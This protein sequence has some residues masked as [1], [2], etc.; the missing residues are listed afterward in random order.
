M[1]NAPTRGEAT[2]LSLWLHRSSVRESITI[3]A[4]QCRQI[5][6]DHY[7]RMDYTFNP[8]QEIDL[9]EH[10]ARDRL[11]KIAEEEMQIHINE[12]VV[13]LRRNWM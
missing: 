12:A 4:C 3:P 8:G 11:V 7:H 9:A 2:T 1:A 13:W 10:A 5:L 6:G